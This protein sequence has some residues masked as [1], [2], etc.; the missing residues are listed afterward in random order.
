MELKNIK[1]YL[2]RGDR[3]RIA[4][5]LMVSR[6]L[7]YAVLAGERHN[8][9]IVEAALTIANDRKNNKEKLAEE[10]KNL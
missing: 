2:K 7:V 10:I 3:E 6:A 1:K 4:A 5:Q 8:D 9:E